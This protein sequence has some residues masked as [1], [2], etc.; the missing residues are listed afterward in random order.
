MRCSRASRF[1]AAQKVLNFHADGRTL[2]GGELL[3]VE[4]LGENVR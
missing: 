3:A 1:A 2:A 4:I